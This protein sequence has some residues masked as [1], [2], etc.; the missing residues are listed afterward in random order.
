MQ[1]GVSEIED[2]TSILGDDSMSSKSSN[3]DD[4]SEAGSS[5]KHQTE[6][7]FYKD[8]SLFLK[9]TQSS[10]PHNDYCQHFVSHA[11]FS[12]RDRKNLSREFSII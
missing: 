11:F 10:N 12:I 7:L 6:S 3:K 2:I 8:S 5:K 4:E 1:L 9:G